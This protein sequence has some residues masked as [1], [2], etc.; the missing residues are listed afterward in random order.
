MQLLRQQVIFEI[1]TEDSSIENDDSSNENDAATADLTET[2]AGS[3]RR[4]QVHG[5][6][7]R[8]TET[9]AGSPPPVVATEVDVEPEPEPEPVAPS[10]GAKNEDLCIPNDGFRIKKDG[11]FITNDEFRQEGLTCASWRPTRY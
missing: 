1:Y 3:R 7:G 2:G 11:I 8:F 5:N 4:G 9:G 10:G 6:G